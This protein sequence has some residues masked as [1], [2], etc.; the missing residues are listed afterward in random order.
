MTEAEWLACTDPQPMLR[1]IGG[2]AGDRKLRLLACA[3]VRRVWPVLPH[4]LAHEVVRLAEDYAD[5]KA[6]SRDAGRLRKPAR[7]PVQ[8]P[9]TWNMLSLAP[10]LRPE[11][12]WEGASQI[13]EA[14]TRFVGWDHRGG[15]PV[16]YVIHPEVV[17]AEGQAQAT[18]VRDIVGPVPFR[19]VSLEGAWRTRKAV[20][21]AQAIYDE[22]AFDRLPIL[23]GALQEAGC[24]SEDIFC[25]A[26]SREACM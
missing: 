14:V 21:L 5:G 8:H 4:G 11:F 7:Q 20:A 25:T 3:C 16:Q 19:A 18:L 12:S 22:R 15:R 2:K 9:S 13:A 6:A 1:V 23:A 26:V 17:R 24:D 10:L